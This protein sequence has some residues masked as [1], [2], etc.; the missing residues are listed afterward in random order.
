MRTVYLVFLA[1]APSEPRLPC[2]YMAAHMPDEV[3]QKDAALNLPWVTF[4]PAAE[5]Q[6]CLV[7]ALEIVERPK[8]AT[9]PTAYRLGPGM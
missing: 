5:M 4:D 3:N 9:E 6:T 2:D 1:A 8:K 7:E